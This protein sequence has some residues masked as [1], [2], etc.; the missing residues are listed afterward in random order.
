MDFRFDSE[1]Q[2][3][4]DQAAATFRKWL[5]PQRLLAVGPVAEAWAGVAEDGWLEVG[6]SDTQDETVPLAL[7]AGIGREAGRVLAGD[8]FVTNAVLLAGTDE[9]LPPGVLLVDGRR[10]EVVE[11]GSGPVP[12]CFGVEDGLPAY[13]IGP[14]GTVQ[15]SREW[16]YS[17][18]ERLALGVGTVTP[19]G[20]TPVARI[21]PTPQLL[22]SAQIVHAATLVGLGEAALAEAVDHAKQRMQFGSP[23][24]RFQAVKHALA[25]AAV[26]AE[27][28]WNAVL[29][30][31]LRPTRGTVDI[32]ALQAKKA[33]DRAT[34]TA[35][36]T[37]GGIAMTWEHEMHLF[38]KTARLSRRRFGHVDEHAARIGADVMEGWNAG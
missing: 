17:P 13:R 10:A 7:V 19:R 32:A 4:L 27:I 34:R 36:Q 16:E 11:G 26:A 30:A 35:V 8:G 23:I 2:R 9:P 18:V 20:S 3:V 28:A 29:Y 21:R 31:A 25:D 37:F 1:D 5:S 6:R 24:G 12:W 38:L 14:D 15:V 33:A 22:L